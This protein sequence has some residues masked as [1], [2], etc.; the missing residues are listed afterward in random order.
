M[1]L[2]DQ[3]ATLVATSFFLKKKQGSFTTLGNMCIKLHLI[4]TLLC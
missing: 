4:W 3:V 2:H 1:L